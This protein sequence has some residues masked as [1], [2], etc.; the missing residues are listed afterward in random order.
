MREFADAKP[1]AR[2]HIRSD[3]RVR[4]GGFRHLEA[5]MI[6]AQKALQDG[7]EFFHTLTGQCRIVRPI[8]EFEAFF[9][10]RRSSNFL[11][12]FPLPSEI[13]P[14]GGLDRIRYFQLFDVLDAKRN[15]LLRLNGPFVRLQR[16]LGVDRLDPGT[17][18]FGGSTYYSINQTAMQYLLGEY[19][20]QSKR[21]RHTLCSE[22][23]A[24]HTI[25]CNGLAGIRDS[26]VNDNLRFVLWR[27]KHGET[28][29]ILDLEDRAEIAASE[30]YFARKFDVISHSLARSLDGASSPRHEGHFAAR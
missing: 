25:L 9:L 28:P 7:C 2:I 22:E 21:Y 24:P 29:G 10:D 27:P 23:I 19:L 8:P 4:W 11:E 13:W 14:G 12:H 15:P 18:Y 20:K 5:F 6:L 26:L 3:L 1:D 30:S 17:R 16:M